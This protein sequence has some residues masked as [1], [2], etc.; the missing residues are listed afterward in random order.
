MGSSKSKSGNI[1]N[2][3]KSTE[4][5]EQTHNIDKELDINSVIYIN[6][7]TS[8]FAEKPTRLL[9]YKTKDVTEMKQSLES[10]M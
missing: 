4:D 3:N 9:R 8:C 6:N 2:T 5:K 1:D 7:T 10:K